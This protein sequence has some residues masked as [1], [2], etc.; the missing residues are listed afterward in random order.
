M[1]ARIIPLF[2]DPVAQEAVAM[3][4]VPPG[5]REMRRGFLDGGL[6]DYIV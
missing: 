2:C 5:A 3:I 4:F 1:P 6:K